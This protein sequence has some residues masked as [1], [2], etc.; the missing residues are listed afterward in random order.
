MRRYAL[1]CGFNGGWLEGLEVETSGL[2]RVVG[3]HPG[4]LEGEATAPRLLV[5]DRRLPL[6]EAYRTFRPDV[7]RHV[8]GDDFLGAVY[9]YRFPEER[10]G[11]RVAL[12]VEVDAKTVYRVKERFDVVRPHYE[13]L[14]D[15]GEVWHREQVYAF[16]PP[17]PEVGT[18]VARLAAALA[19]PVLDFGCGSGALVAMLR[20]GGVE[21]HG[22]ELARPGIEESLFPEAREHVTLYDGAF[23]LPYP[24][25]RFESAI[26]TEVIEHVPEFERALAEIARVTRSA[27]VVT[28]PDASSI[29]VCHHNDVVP[30]HLLESTHYNFFCQT[31]LRRALE[32]HF[33]SIAFA[34]IVPHATNGSVWYGSLAAVCRK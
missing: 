11:A 4:G 2:V 5:A 26:A 12:A 17:S 27:F 31:S 14:L 16:G 24:D 13:Q 33:A 1:R 19:G 8:G 10:A 32:R 23:P 21:A 15:A 9:V 18:E 20:R 7:G 6:F 29:P 25:G 34:R 28:V 30:W 22:I 3:W